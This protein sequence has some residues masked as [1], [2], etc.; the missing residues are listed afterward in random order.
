M[1]LSNYP[2]GCSEREINER[3]GPPRCTE[4][5]TEIE[6]DDDAFDHDDGRCPA[7]RPEKLEEEEKI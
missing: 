2:P 4:C 6:D 5:R 7:C 1:S 3:F